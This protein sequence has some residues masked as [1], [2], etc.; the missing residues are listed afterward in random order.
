MRALVDTAQE[1]GLETFRDIL[2]EEFLEV[3]AEEPGSAAQRVELVQ[4]AAVTVKW[5]AALDRA[6]GGAS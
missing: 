2:T 3:L 6:N 5:I 1:V 4:L